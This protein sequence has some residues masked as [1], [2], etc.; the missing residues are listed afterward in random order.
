M[1]PT[2]MC[3]LTNLYNEGH[4]WHGRAHCNLNATVVAA[5]GWSDW[6]ED[7]VPDDVILER[8]FKFNLEQ[9]KG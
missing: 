2:K 5:Y 9:A 7:G 1:R 3:T 8:L 6:V 4:A